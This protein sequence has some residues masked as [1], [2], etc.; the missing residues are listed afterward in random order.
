MLKTLTFKD[1]EEL[2]GDRES[3]AMWYRCSFIKFLDNLEINKINI[4]VYKDQSFLMMDIFF[5]FLFEMLNNA[6]GE[7]YLALIGF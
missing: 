4:N 3:G 5:S 2:E 7:V 1:E 6:T